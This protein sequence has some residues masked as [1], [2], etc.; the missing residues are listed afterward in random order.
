MNVN[1]SARGPIFR[2]SLTPPLTVGTFT[3]NR[4][5]LMAGNRCESHNESNTSL[6]PFGAAE[7][8]E[9]VPAYRSFFRASCYRPDPSDKEESR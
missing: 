2:P 1:H 8:D 9:H 4:L 7:P 5:S 6:I 3:T